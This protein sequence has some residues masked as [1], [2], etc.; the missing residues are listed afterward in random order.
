MLARVPGDPSRPPVLGPVVDAQTR[1]VHYRSPL[2]V[3]ALRFACCGSYY[4]CHLCHEEAAGHPSRTWPAS[5]RDELAVLCGV[6]SAELTI[7]EY[8]R[9]DGCPACSAPFNPGCAL[10]EHLYFDADASVF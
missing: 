5:A 1:C 6:C 7:A 8:R 9:S 3:I 10:H 2:D 4:P